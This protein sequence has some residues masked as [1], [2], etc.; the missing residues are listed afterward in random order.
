MFKTIHSVPTIR[1]AGDQKHNSY[2]ESV[3]G[4]KKELELGE[5]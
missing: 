1:K 3:K 2:K 4:Q 5:N